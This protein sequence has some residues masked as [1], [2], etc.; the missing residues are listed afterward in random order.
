LSHLRCA[1]EACTSIDVGG[2][3]LLELELELGADA[4]EA[5]F[6]TIFAQ[7]DIW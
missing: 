4:D 5:V 1:E 7:D 3:D 6:F 2:T